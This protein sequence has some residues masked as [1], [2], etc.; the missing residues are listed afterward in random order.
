MFTAVDEK[1][2]MSGR[3]KSY[4]VRAPHWMPEQGQLSVS[5]ILIERG[6]MPRGRVMKLDSE[7]ILE[8]GDL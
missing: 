7:S 6:A 8:T 3:H 1:H 4:G 2:I 5:G